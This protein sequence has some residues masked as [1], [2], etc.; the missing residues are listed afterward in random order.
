VFKRRW[1]RRWWLRLAMLDLLVRWGFWLRLC[2]RCGY[3][4]ICD[5]YWCDS[6]LDLRLHFPGETATQWWLWRLVVW[7]CP[8]PD[9]A[10]LLSIPW[11]EY[12]QRSIRKREPF[13][14]S[15][16]E[17]ERRLQQYERMASDEHWTVLDGRRPPAELAG[18]IASSVAGDDG[19]LATLSQ[20]IA[21]PDSQFRSA[22]P[23][24]KMQN[25]LT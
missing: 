10:F 24:S 8:K 21:K 5:R 19:P 13:P 12:Q 1:V 23:K 20:P 16:A 17:F 18:V 22:T 14:L 9:S 4:V 6:E 25:R 15:S 2:R 11:N 3:V 7:F